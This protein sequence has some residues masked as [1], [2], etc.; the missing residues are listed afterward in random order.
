MQ[1]LSTLPYQAEGS[2][3]TS[4]HAE[5]YTGNLRL[6]K[7]SAKRTWSEVSMSGGQDAQCFKRQNLGGAQE[8]MG[9]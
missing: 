5:E 2:V 7:G 1:W 9:K 3:C 4:H 6:R 8:R